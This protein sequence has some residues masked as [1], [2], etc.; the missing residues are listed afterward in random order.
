MEKFLARLKEKAKNDP[1]RIVFPESF[2]DRILKAVD[3]LISQ[4]LCKVILLGEKDK[5]MWRAGELGL[6]ISKAVIINPKQDSKEEEYAHVYYQ[7]RKHKGMTLVSARKLMEHS[8]LFGTMMVYMGAAD[9][10]VSGASHPTA[11]TLRPALQVIRTKEGTP[12]ASS[13]FFIIGAER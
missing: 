10:L 9:G 4:G 8:S 13:F 6:N 11:E 5:I 1:K 2:D 12:T 3:I 7:L